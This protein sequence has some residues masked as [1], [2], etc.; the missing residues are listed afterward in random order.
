MIIPEES[1]MTLIK[2]EDSTNA[3]QKYIYSNSIFNN[4]DIEN[5]N[6][7]IGEISGYLI[8]AEK[9]KF[10]E[11]F[12]AFANLNILNIFNSLVDLNIT[13]L[14]LCILEA[15]NFL[16]LNLKNN[17]IKLSIYSTKYK[18]KIPGQEMNIIDKLNELNLEDT[19]EFLSMQINFMKSLSLKLDNNNIY[20][21]FNKDINQ[22]QMLTKSFSLYNNPDPMVRNV[23]KNILLSIMRIDNK[24]IKNFLV[25]FP[26]NIY[27]TNLILNFKNYILQLCLID[28]S[29]IYNDSIFGIFRRKHD[30][31]IDISMYL[32]DILELNIKPINFMLIK[33]LYN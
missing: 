5:I 24:D 21:F 17:E 11:Y 31:L 1:E 30:E 23:V 10:P 16:I 26:I 18:T 3:L 7:I 29:E 14:S 19:D 9:K 22:F 32:G 6:K 4:R 2:F 15:L 25:S 13:N 8:A 20:Y 12:T 27:Y 33:F 28:L